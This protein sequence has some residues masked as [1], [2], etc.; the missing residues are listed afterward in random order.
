MLLARLDA[1]ELAPARV[2]DSCSHLARILGNLLDNARRPA[3]GTV[4]VLLHAG[5]G[6]AVVEVAGDGAGVPEA[7]WARFVRLDD[8]RSRDDGGAGL[9]LAIARDFARRQ[10]EP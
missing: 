9:G 2:R 3:A 6:E 4:R 1:G 5:A 10:A 8:A 7:D